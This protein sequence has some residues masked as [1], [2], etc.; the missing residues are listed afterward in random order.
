[1]KNI[2]ALALAVTI[3]LSSCATQFNINEAAK[4]GHKCPS[5]HAKKLHKYG[6]KYYYSQ[7]K[8]SPSTL[9]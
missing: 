6:G 9:V 4:F 3:A 7:M 8:L 1:M 2:L 5:K